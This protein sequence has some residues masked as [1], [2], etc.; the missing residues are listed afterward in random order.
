MAHPYD[1]I[2]ELRCSG[3]LHAVS[4]RRFQFDQPDLGEYT[5]RLLRAYINLLQIKAEIR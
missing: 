4:L 5:Q 1:D 3:R 2:C